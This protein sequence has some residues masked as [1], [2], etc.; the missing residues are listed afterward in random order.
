MS[1]LIAGLAV[2]GATVAPTGPVLQLG[3]PAAALFG[4]PTF[5]DLTAN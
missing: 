4:R 5:S 3:L 1:Q 2:G